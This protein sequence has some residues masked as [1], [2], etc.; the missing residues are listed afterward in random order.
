MSTTPSKDQICQVWSALPHG[1]YDLVLPKNGQKFESLAHLMIKWD[2]ELTIYILNKPLGYIV[3]S[4]LFI[5]FGGW[6]NAKYMVGSLLFGML[7]FLV[8]NIDSNVPTGWD[9]V[10]SFNNQRQVRILYCFQK[11]SYIDQYVCGKVKVSFWHLQPIL[12]FLT[13][14]KDLTTLWRTILVY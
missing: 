1:Y 10:I 7:L 5:W 8:Y 6:H 3:H 4:W 2:L 13:Q 12:Y 9:I 11:W 14:D